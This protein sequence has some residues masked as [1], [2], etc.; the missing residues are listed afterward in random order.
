MRRIARSCCVRRM[1][2]RSWRAQAL[3]VTS[4]LPRQQRPPN[5]SSAPGTVR[6]WDLPTRLTHW[7]LVVLVSL[8]LSTGAF[9]LPE[10]L[11]LHV[12]SGVG[13][14]AA[15]A[16]R[17]AWGFF[18]P[19][20]SR[21]GGAL[22]SPRRVLDRL[23]GRDRA[24]YL[25]HNPLAGFVLFSL[26]LA[27]A[28]TVATGLVVLGGEEQRGPLAASLGWATGRRA[29][30]LHEGLAWAI[31]G[32]ILAHGLGLALESRKLA[33]N[34]PLSMVTGWRRRPPSGAVEPPPARRRPVLGGAL[35]GAMVLAL[36]AWV[37]GSWGARPSGW[38]P[39]SDQ[40]DF[41][42][43]E[44]ECGACH[45]L[46]HPSLLPAPEWER[47]M[48]GLD[49]HFG[50]D[51]SLLPRASAR[52]RAL[53]IANGNLRWDTEVA[54]ELRGRRDPAR[55]MEV[56]A[57]GWWLEQHRDLRELASDL[58]GVGSP[59]NCDGCHPDAV[60]GRFEGHRIAVPEGDAG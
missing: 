46:Y 50:E 37:L 20:P 10:A 49:E 13:I 3:R 28:A 35:F 47:L 38:R 40:P 19:A 54:N 44:A 60:E 8:S 30:G 2:S 53:L 29:H 21:L 25:G 51:A 39:M 16:F 23:R 7:S 55:P 43:F 58:P 48:A 59:G 11:K 26:L 36:V 41:S 24:T 33:E 18:G 34:L 15:L 52:I 14:A 17:L 6:L 22:Y 31:V 45:A 12:A 42:L 5:A 56:T 27:L 4:P 32:A 9:A 1:S 57:N